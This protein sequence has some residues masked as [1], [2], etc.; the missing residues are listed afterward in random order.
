VTS[1]KA[2]A[3]TS[4]SNTAERVGEDDAAGETTVE[5]LPEVRDELLDQAAWSNVLDDFACTLGL[6]AQLTDCEGRGL[7]ACF[8]PQPIWT[9]TKSVSHSTGGEGLGPFGVESSPSLTVKNALRTGRVEMGREPSGL[10]HLAVPLSLGRDQLGAIIAGQ[11]FD[12]Y[13]DPLRMQRLARH[14]GLSS[15]DLWQLARQQVPIR[16]FTLNLYGQLLLTLGKAFLRQRYAAILARGLSKTNLRLRLL[17]DG[18]EG[19]ALFTVDQSGS[20]TSWN[21]GAERMFGYAESEVIGRGYACFFTPDDIDAGAPEELLHQRRPGT[22]IKD[23]R[24][25]IRKDGSHFFA[26][27]SITALG[28]GDSLEYGRL[29]IDATDRRSAEEALGHKQKLESIGVLASGIAHDFNNLLTSVLLG[30]SFAKSGLPGEHPACRWL[31]NAEEA[32]EKAADLANQ[33]LAYGGKGRFLV[34]RFNL[35][36]LIRE[37]V[38]LLQTSIPKTVDLQLMLEP[39]IPWIEADA[40]QIQ[41]IVMNLVINGAESIGAEGGTLRVSTGVAPPGKISTDEA[42]R[43]YMEVQDSGSGMTEATLGRIFDPFFTTKFSGRG[44]GLAAVAGIVSGHQGTMEVESVIG[45]GSTFRIYFPAAE[46]REE[47][48]PARRDGLPTLDA[49]D[50]KGIGTILVV[51][52]ESGLREIASGILEHAGYKVLTAGDGREAVEVFREHADFVTVVLLDMTMPVMNGAEAFALIRAIRPEVP[53]VVST[54]YSE[55]ATREMFNKGTTVGFVHKPY[56]AERLCE[57]IRTAS[58]VVKARAFPNG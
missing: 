16:S 31:S 10:V 7:S 51:D 3:G 26:E 12:Q 6:A 8:N 17:L 29:A 43:I 19:H 58:E 55:V 25:Q 56:T 45:T 48:A 4:L 21:G 47:K 50:V 38:N 53:I 42:I 57:R 37:M 11:V 52:D 13:P 23:G 22:S 20:I 46:A 2:P 34:T 32:S 5:L 24:W 40:S 30:I 27:G 33:L 36:V 41:Q 39:E 28:T 14:L 35:S 1:Q 54:G 9:L 18:V 15:Q 49:L 44:L